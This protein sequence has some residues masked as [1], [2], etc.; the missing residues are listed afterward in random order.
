MAIKYLNKKNLIDDELSEIDFDFM[1][2]WNCDY[3]NEESDDPNDF[4]HYDYIINQNGYADGYPIK[5]DRVIEQ[6]QKMKDAGCN[7]IEMD[8][9]CDHIGY[10]FSG[11]LIEE[12]T[13]EQIEEFLNK[14]KEKE[15]K[16]KEI[17]ELRQKIKELEYGK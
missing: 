5:I 17:R 14:K 1:R 8:Y 11:F 3:D 4:H 16:E 6:L 12:A 15:A 10:Q 13:A 9:H 7:Y 2:D